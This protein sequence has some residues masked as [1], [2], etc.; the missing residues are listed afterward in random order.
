MDLV[1]WAGGVSIVLDSLGKLA[2]VHLLLEQV[3]LDNT[4][5][6]S[7]FNLSGSKTGEP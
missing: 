5:A 6:Q 3:S 2:C 4:G 1:L 7:R